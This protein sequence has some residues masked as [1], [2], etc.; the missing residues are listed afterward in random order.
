L[1][2]PEQSPKKFQ[3]K[4]IED[5]SVIDNSGG[6]F[7]TPEEELGTSEKSLQMEQSFQ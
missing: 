3:Q 7:V 4:N 6:P 2:G 1:I 5:F